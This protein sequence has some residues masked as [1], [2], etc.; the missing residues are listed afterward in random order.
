[1]FGGGVARFISAAIGGL[2]ID[3][4]PLTKPVLHGHGWRSM[5]VQPAP[6][7]IRTLG[8]ASASRR[9]PYGLA[10]VAWKLR[11]EVGG[12]GTLELNLT[13][14]VG[15][16]AVVR[17]PVL[18]DVEATDV[19]G[20]S[21]DVATMSPDSP[22]GEC[23]MTCPLAEQLGSVAPVSMSDSRVATCGWKYADALCE[24][25]LDGELVLRFVAL[26]GSHRLRIS[27]P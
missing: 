16:S 25:R 19:Q 17:L 12:E 20:A 4:A 27:K 21:F 26:S 6:H 18:L 13:V 2:T 8:H 14:P 5:L 24:W 1:M 10:S 7:A 11:E 3:S 23:A 22:D 9:T 15:S